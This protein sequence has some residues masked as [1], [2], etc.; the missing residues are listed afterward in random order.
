MQQGKSK[1]LQITLSVM[2]WFG[3]EFKFKATELVQ[4]YVSY[5]STRVKYDQIC[6]LVLVLLVLGTRCFCGYTCGLCF[7]SSNI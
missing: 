2:G 7:G 1:Y 6:V 4:Q 3:Q 5:C